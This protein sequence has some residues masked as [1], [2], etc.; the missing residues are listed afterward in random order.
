MTLKTAL[1]TGGLSLSLASLPIAVGIVPPRIADTHTLTWILLY[2]KYVSLAP[3][4]L[5]LV[6]V[7]W[8]LMLFGFLVRIVLR[9]GFTCETKTAK[10]TGRVQGS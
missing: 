1:T 2:T 8:E 3:E 5:R 4:P 9:C 10:I 7:G 6:I